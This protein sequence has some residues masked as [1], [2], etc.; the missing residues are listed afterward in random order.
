MSEHKHKHKHSKI[1]EDAISAA[2]CKENVIVGGC[3]TT[4]SLGESILFIQYLDDTCPET[5]KTR[6]KW[7]DRCE[8]RSKEGAIEELFD[9]GCTATVKRS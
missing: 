8:V 5:R 9:L 4:A 2:E 7:A 3:S 1:S 6:K